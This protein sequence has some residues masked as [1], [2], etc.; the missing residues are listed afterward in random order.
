VIS[1][2]SLFSVLFIYHDSHDHWQ[3]DVSFDEDRNRLRSGSAAENIALMNK[4]S[5]I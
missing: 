5:F 3:L 4:I 1:K 2:V